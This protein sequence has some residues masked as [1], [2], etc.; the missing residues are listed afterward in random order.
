MDFP[1]LY[2]TL[3]IDKLSRHGLSNNVHCECL[4]K[5]K[6]NKDDMVQKYQAVATSWSV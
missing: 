4:P 6:E 2:M 3:A 5:K 1:F